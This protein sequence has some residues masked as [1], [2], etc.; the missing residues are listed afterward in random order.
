[1]TAE[2]AAKGFPIPMRG[3]EAYHEEG[4]TVAVVVSDSH[5]G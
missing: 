1:M 3:N 5:E 4:D 2:D